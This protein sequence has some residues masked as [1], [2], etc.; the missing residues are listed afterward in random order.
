MRYVRTFRR[1]WT[2]RI[3]G[4]EHGGVEYALTKADWERCQGRDAG[5]FRAKRELTGRTNEVRSSFASRSTGL[6][7]N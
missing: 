7:S 1:G 5:S 4:D 6:V 2:E 3:A